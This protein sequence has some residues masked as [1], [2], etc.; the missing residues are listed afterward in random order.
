MKTSTSVFAP[1]AVS[2]QPVPGSRPLRVVLVDEELPYPPTSGKRIRTLNLTVRLARRHQ[3]TYLCHRHADPEEARA[4]SDFFHQ[5]GIRTVVVERAI[6]PKS[7]PLFH[8][9]LLANLLS[10]LPYSVSTHN[11]R[12]LR[13]TLKTYAASEPVD[14]WHC[15]WTPYAQPLQVV[16]GPR[17]IIAHNVESVIWQRYHETESNPLKRWYIQRQW[18]KFQRFEARVLAAAERTVAVS[19]VDAARLQSDFGVERLAV[20]ENGVDLTYFAPQE[21]LRDPGNILFLGS[22]D[23]RPNLDGVRFLLERIFPLVRQHEPTATLSLVGRNPPDWLARWVETLPG[24]QLHGNVPDVRPFLAECGLMVVPL[25]VG[26]GSRLKIL[27]SLASGTPVVSTRIG[28]EG[29]DLDPRQH[30]T[31]VESMNDLPAALV[32]TIQ[33]PQ[34]ARLQAECGRQRVLELYGWDRLA[35]QLDE[36]WRRCAAQGAG[37]GDCMR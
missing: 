19:A 36:V 1:P 27:E 13:H 25:R 14:L 31:V 18:R 6:P 9:R 17:L 29:L 3:L 15:E 23:W 26:G 2:H 12:A 11:S 4:A 10:P 20:V 32:S 7:G 8:A 16:P 22:L 21:A 28:A 34:E 35:E 33:S 24:V 5:H 30:L 37:L